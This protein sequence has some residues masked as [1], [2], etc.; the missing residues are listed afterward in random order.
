MV[1]ALFACSKSDNGGVTDS[2]NITDTSGSNPVT[3]NNGNE[4]DTDESFQ[5]SVS[6]I[7]DFIG[8]DTEK[9][10]YI[11]EYIGNARVVMIPEELDGKKVVGIENDAFYDHGDFEEIVYSS[12]I[13]EIEDYTFSGAYNLKK[14]TLNEGLVNIGENAFVSCEKLVEVV[15][16][17]TLKS[18]GNF[19][20]CECKSL[21]TIQLP[22]GL[23]EIGYTVFGNCCIETITFP[24]T[25]GVLEKGVVYGCSELKK[26][27]ILG[28]DTV[29]E[30]G[31]VFDSPNAVIY[32]YGGSTAET[33]A[34]NM[35][36]EFVTIQ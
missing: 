17:S 33:Y 7:D 20:F 12:G 11:D 9:G 36:M 24:S 26:V 35:E 5:D 23:T 13:T 30:D 31:A 6:S 1:F 18:I 8:I 22:E 15:I 34:Q 32:G 27:Y 10:Y 21:S 2:L 14:V 19:A 29:I 25:I 16:P 3:E 4:Q 28:K